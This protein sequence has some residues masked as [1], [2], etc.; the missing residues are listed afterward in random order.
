MKTNRYIE[1]KHDFEIV[2]IR[3]GRYVEHSETMEKQ[4]NCNLEFVAK[5]LPLLSEK[6]NSVICPYGI[7]SVLTIAAEGANKD[8]LAQILQVLGFNSLEELRECVLA[9]QDVQYSTFSSDNGLV[10]QQG[11]EKQELLSNFRKI[12]EE[13]YNASVEEVSSEGEASFLLKNVANFKAEWLYEMERD[14]SHEEIFR[15]ADG[16]S[17]N[18]AFLSTKQEFLR[19]YEDEFGNG[20]FASL[21]AIALPYRIQGERIPYELILVDSK[22][23]LTKESLHNIL[24]RMRL[25]RCTVVFPEFSIKSNNNLVP[26]MKHL[27]LNTIFNDSEALDK[28]ATHP[29]CAKEFSQEAEIEVDKNGTV[30]R[31]VTEM[32]DSHIGDYLDWDEKLVFNKPFHYFLR[33]T[34]TGE[35]VFMGKVNIL[36]DY[37]RTK[38]VA[39]PEFLFR[40][41]L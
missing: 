12:I 34:T 15:N 29:L 23:A 27:G 10:L 37:I 4:S 20:A 38:T 18:P 32:T 3:E 16:S 14:I 31:A 36:E 41:F 33:N 1:K 7:A 25:N 21:K 24:G 2:D 6:D 30:A 13:R 40:M 35:I 28:I 5:L 19:Y 9:V 22:E 8:C 11:E 39:V 26:L 17:S